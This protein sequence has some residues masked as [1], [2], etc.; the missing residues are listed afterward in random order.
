MKASHDYAVWLATHTWPLQNVHVADGRSIYQRMYD[1]GY[2]NFTLWGE[3]AAINQSTA[4][5]AMNGWKGSPGHNQ[6]MLFCGIKAMGAGYAQG[7]RHIW[8]ANFGN[9]VYGNLAQ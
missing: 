7:S 5:G 8:I 6:M 4:Q 9:Y 1:A 2:R 3:I